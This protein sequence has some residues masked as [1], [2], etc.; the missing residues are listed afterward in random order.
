[1]SIL[2]IPFSPLDHILPT[3]PL[4][5]SQQSAERL[6]GW[7]TGVSASGGEACYTGFWSTIWGFFGWA[8]VRRACRVVEGLLQDSLSG[9]CDAWSPH[10]KKSVSGAVYSSAVGPCFRTEMLQNFSLILWTCCFLH[11]HT[12]VPKPMYLHH[13]KHPVSKHQRRVLQVKGLNCNGS[14]N[15]ASRLAA[16][17]AKCPFV[18]MSFFSW[19][20]VTACNYWSF[21]FRLWNCYGLAMSLHISGVSPKSALIF[22][23]ASRW[24]KCVHDRILDKNDEGI[25]CSLF[26]LSELDD[27]PK[28]RNNCF[29]HYASWAAIYQ[30]RMIKLVCVFSQQTAWR[31]ASTKENES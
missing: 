14:L 20:F 1:M 28:N 17:A 7:C 13:P 4:Q 6:S 24:K 3:M 26:H 29:N 31:Y 22:S 25:S 23:L 19:Q 18:G 16:V 27:D 9:C 15:G 5:R 30:Q 12:K 11:H 10:H 21:Y 2:S 8:I